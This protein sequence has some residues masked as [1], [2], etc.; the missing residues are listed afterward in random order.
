MEKIFV[1]LV[2]AMFKSSRQHSLRKW[3][4]YECAINN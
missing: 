4:N 2:V 1:E 3:H